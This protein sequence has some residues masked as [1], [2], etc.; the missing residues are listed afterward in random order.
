MAPVDDIE[1]YCDNG[2]WKTRWR[3]SPKPFAAGGGRERQVF[4]GATVAQ[5]YGVDHII[6]NP[7]GTTAE[8]NSYRYR[9]EA[10]APLDVAPRPPRNSPLTAAARAS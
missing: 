2:I 6:I 5:W 7:D 9:K 1:T 10:H 4:Q 8:H 3:S